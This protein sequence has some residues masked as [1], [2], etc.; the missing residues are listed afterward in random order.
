MMIIKL[1]IHKL[2][3]PQSPGRKY[4][5]GWGSRQKGGMLTLAVGLQ[6]LYA[7]CMYILKLLLTIK[8]TRQKGG[9]LTT[10]GCYATGERGYPLFVFCVI[11][12]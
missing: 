7:L 2:E 11:R 3:L 1:P 9:M 8:K 6:S 10:V 4:S 5:Q 12:V